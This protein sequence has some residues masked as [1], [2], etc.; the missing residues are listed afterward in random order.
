MIPILLVKYGPA[1]V[2]LAKLAMVVAPQVLAIYQQ[3]RQNKAVMS[4]KPTPPAKV[5]FGRKYPHPFKG[6]RKLK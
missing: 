4:D 3:H 2:R 5:P 6:P 1:A